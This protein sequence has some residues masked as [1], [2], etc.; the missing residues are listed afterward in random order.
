MC[1]FCDALN[2]EVW[3]IS[4][5]LN[6]GYVQYFKN[7][8][9]TNLGITAHMQKLMLAGSHRTPLKD[10]SLA[11]SSCGLRAG[12]RVWVFLRNGREQLSTYKNHNNETGRCGVER[13]VKVSQQRFIHQGRKMV[14]KKLEDYNIRALST[15]CMTFRPKGG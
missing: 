8:I 11:V 5:R 10:D 14:S 7:L 1:S 12:S 3:S 4:K 13:V 2:G 9:E 6:N 15:I